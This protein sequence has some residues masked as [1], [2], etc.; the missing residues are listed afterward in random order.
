MDSTCFNWGVLVVTWDIA[1]LR[2]EFGYS[3][4]VSTDQPASEAG[5]DPLRWFKYCNSVASLAHVASSFWMKHR[6]SRHHRFW[7]AMA[8][9]CRI[10]AAQWVK[11]QFV[12]SLISCWIG[13]RPGERC[14]AAIGYIGEPVSIEPIGLSQKRCLQDIG[15]GLLDLQTSQAVFVLGRRSFANLEGRERNKTAKPEKVLTWPNVCQ[16]AALFLIQ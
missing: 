2:S 10:A 11:Q 9:A 8:R 15:R 7:S 3:V 14:R 4:Q 5:S 16:N 1:G 13:R 6:F 12:G